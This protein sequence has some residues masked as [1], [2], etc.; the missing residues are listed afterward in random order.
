[1]KQ[2]EI[3]YDDLL[4]M[5]EK[6]PK[7]KLASLFASFWKDKEEMKADTTSASQSSGSKEEMNGNK[8]ANGEQQEN[9]TDEGKSDMKEEKK[10]HCGHSILDDAKTL[11][12]TDLDN[13]LESDHT[14]EPEVGNTDVE[15]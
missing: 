9:K 14:G 4:A 5:M 3:Q 7:D 6:L 2:N 8:E 12:F 15:G 1:M 11:L 10:P 13:S